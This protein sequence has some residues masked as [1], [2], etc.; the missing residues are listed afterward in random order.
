MRITDYT[1]STSVATTDMFVAET[2]DGT[3]K[4]S[5]KTM[6]LAAY[7]V[8][9]VYIAYTSTSPAS[10]FGGTW[11]QITNKVLRAANNV[12]T[13]GS[14]SVTLTTAQM[15]SHSHVLTGV[16]TL[17]N[18]AS[19]TEGHSLTYTKNRTTTDRESGNTGGGESHSNLPAY[20]N[21][22]VWRRTA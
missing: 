11:T 4:I 2:S 5:G 8:G 12:D 15:P 17:D 6:G 9:S 13:G 7:P 18:S 16:R 3:R 21:L 10:R 19:T 1:E 20:Q 14:D 22:Y